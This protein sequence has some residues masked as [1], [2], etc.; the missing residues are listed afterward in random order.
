MDDNF[1]VSDYKGKTKLGKFS[2]LKCS[3]RSR[4]PIWQ[5]NKVKRSHYW[6]IISIIYIAT[7]VC[8]VS[9][10]VLIAEIRKGLKS[11]FRKNL[12]W[13]TIREESI[14]AVSVDIPSSAIKMKRLCLHN[15][16]IQEKNYA[17]QII[18][19][20]ELKLNRN[21]L[22]ICVWG[23]FNLRCKNEDEFQVVTK[24]KYLP[25]TCFSNWSRKPNNCFFLK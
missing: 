2:I 13:N 16:G 24:L 18:F 25:L 10:D 20:E 12:P 8:S 15:L 3:R 21:Q 6:L 7:C 14:S 19:S 23:S 4:R 11:F 22:H 9:W 5:D 1:R 17:C